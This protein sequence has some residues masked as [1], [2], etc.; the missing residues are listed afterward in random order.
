[1]SLTA[2]GETVAKNVDPTGHWIASYKK[3]VDDL[4]EKD[5]IVSRRP[6]WSIN[7]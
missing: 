1:M 3:T 6:L 5:R 7:R 4:Q 2:A